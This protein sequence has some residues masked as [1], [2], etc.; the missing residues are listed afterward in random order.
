M[1]GGDECYSPVVSAVYFALVD[2]N[3]FYCSCE[4]VFNPKLQNTP[5]VVLSNNDGCIVA[6]SQEVKAANVAMG[7]P[8]FQ[9]KRQLAAMGATV[10]S[11]N[12]QLYGDM[13]QRVMNTLRCFFEH[14]DVYSIDEAFVRLEGMNCDLEQYCSDVS[15]A[16]H[17]WT[18]IPVS[19]GIST[20]KTLAKIA[21]NVAKKHTTSGVFDMRTESDIKRTL[22]DYSV[23]DVWGV[24]KA[25][26]KQLQQHNIHTALQL[27]ATPMTT[28]RGWFGVL[29]QRMSYELQGVAC[30]ED[31]APA[32]KKSII[33]SR[34][35]GIDLTDKTLV[36]QALASYTARAFAKLRQQASVAQFV[37]IFLEYRNPRNRQR[38]LCD[39][40][41]C[42]FAMAT[43]DSRQAL[44]MVRDCIDAIYTTGK[45]YKKGGVILSGISPAAQVQRDL[46]SPS[47]SSKSK[48]VMAALDTINRKMGATTIQLAVQGHSRPWAMQCNH[49]SPRYTTQWSELMTVKS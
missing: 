27:R 1:G 14:V 46:F 39:S 28:M 8:Y 5:V 17:Q 13:S 24:G 31:Q 6:R 29:G 30:V 19:I 11:S 48:A 18:G 38:R 32:P 44:A 34:S 2:C 40:S 43:A 15:N 20:T 21:N 42:E 3:N 9:F 35:F 45:V 36:H 37:N 41:S 23:A 10:F 25:W 7:A 22:R 49:R 12:Y 47:D 26:N 4:R 16:V 33:T